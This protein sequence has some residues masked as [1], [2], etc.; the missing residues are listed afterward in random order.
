MEEVGRILH[1]HKVDKIG[2][3]RKG[4]WSKIVEKKKG[5]GE[6]RE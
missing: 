2:G 5:G 4:C 6:I 1:S 3:N